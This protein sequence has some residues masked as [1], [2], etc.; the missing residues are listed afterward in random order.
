MPTC[1][2]PWGLPWEPCK[3][4]TDHFLWCSQAMSEEDKDCRTAGE[5]FLALSQT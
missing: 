4:L 1:A 2:C 3:H 5:H